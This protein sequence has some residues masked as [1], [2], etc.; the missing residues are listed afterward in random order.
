[1][2]PEIKS[3][4]QFTSYDFVESNTLR[5][6]YFYYPEDPSDITLEFFINKSGVK[7]AGKKILC[8]S[9]QWIKE[10]LPMVKTIS[11]SSVPHSNVYK[12]QGISKQEAQ[13]KLNNYYKSLGFSSENESDHFFK[14]TVDAIV[15]KTCATT[16]GKTRRRKTRK[17]KY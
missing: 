11:L 3:Q 16:G 1:M 4:T 10:N 5:I 6:Q 14:S 17:H 8:D 15:A 2:K 9:L 13:K 7:G 12:K